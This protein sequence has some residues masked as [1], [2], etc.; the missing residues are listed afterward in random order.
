MALKQVLNT[1]E[2]MT[3][4][5]GC[6]YV[7]HE[8]VNIPLVEVGSYSVNMEWQSVDK[9]PVGHIDVQSVPTGVR[10]TLTCT[11]MVVRDDIWAEEML[12]TIQKGKFPVYNFQCRVE[13]PDGQEQRLM[14]NN[15]VPSGNFGLQNVTPGE[16]VEREM[17]FRLNDIP[18]YISTIA[19]T[20]NYL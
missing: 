4:K 5:D 9:Q 15:A 20:F 7:E 16:V 19:S 2:L 12:A 10:F 17:N 1:S 14:L 11:E 18:A 6:L 13:K 8:G 3:G